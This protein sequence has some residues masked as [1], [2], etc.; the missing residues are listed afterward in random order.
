MLNPALHKPQRD[1]HHLRTTCLGL[2]FEVS[3]VIRH[4]LVTTVIN[5]PPKALLAD[6]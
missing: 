3:L 1:P 2:A 4:E 5:G 6:R